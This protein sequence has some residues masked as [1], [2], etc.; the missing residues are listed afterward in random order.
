MDLASERTLTIAPVSRLVRARKLSP[1]EITQAVLDRIARLQPGL[2]A[3]I[4]IADELAL[5]QARKAEKEILRG[6][7]RGVLHG[8]PI[9]LKDLIYVKGMRTTAGS[10]ILRDFVPDENAAVVDRLASAGVV[11]VGKTNLHEFAYGPTNLNPHYGPVRNPWDTERMSGGSSGGS[12]VAVVAGLALASL[13]TDTGG[14]IRIPAAA[15]GCVGLKP[16]YG[17]VPLHGVIPLATSLDHIGPLCRCVEDAALLLECIAGADPRDPFSSGHRDEPFSRDLRK[18]LK[19][20]RVGVPRQ[21]FFD[22]LQRDVRRNVLAA[23]AALEQDGAMVRELDLKLMDESAWLAT[24]ITHAE[25]ILYHWEW[26]QKRPEDYGPDV[27]LR[28]EGGGA[29]SA[30]KYLLAQ[31]RRRLYTLE[32]E[33]TLQRVDV[34]AVPTLPIVAPRIDEP[35]VR[36]GHSS[37]DTR[38]ALLRFTRPANLAGLPA[39]SLPCGFSSENLPVGLQLIGHRYGERTL[40]RIAYAY[41]QATPWHQTLPP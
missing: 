30:S 25:A 22:R 27:R 41:E 40:L 35:S 7:Y 16:T 34:L 11:L 21:Y 26:L 36:I 3:F 31:E 15:C 17:R 9:C 14:S 10:K 2:N 8:I 18:G 19:G 32:F 29:V 5:R 28:L 37:E 39:I 6:K 38:L 33:N 12:A 13:G 23:I 1:V 20:T 4:T 24:E